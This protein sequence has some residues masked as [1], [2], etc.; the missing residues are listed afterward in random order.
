MPRPRNQDDEEGHHDED[1]GAKA[2]KD[3]FH[4][5][6]DETKKRTATWSAGTRKIKAYSR[7]LPCQFFFYRLADQFAVHSGPGELRH[8]VLH[9]GAHILH[10]GRAHFGDGG[11]DGGNDISL[12]NSPRHVGFDD[13]DF[14]SFFF[15]KLGTV[16]LLKRFDRVFALLDERAEDL[17]LFFFVE[18]AA[19]FD[20]LVFEGGFH[21]AQGGETK[22][23][24][25]AHGSDHV[26]L[27]LLGLGH[28][29]IIVAPPQANTI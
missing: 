28:G 1:R 7:L 5:R 8:H 2:Q 20:L 23:V 6:V 16:S 29:A 27:H 24:S 21:Q 12:A 11:F 22:L 4:F 17:Q 3:P 9:Y 18:G 26:L 19:L 13:D 25:G 14:L 15:G 10:C